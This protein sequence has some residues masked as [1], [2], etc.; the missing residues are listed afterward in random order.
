MLART[1]QDGLDVMWKPKSFTPQELDEIAAKIKDKC[2]YIDA[3]GKEVQSK[4]KKDAAT[5]SA[6]KQENR[7]EGGQ[8]EEALYRKPKEGW[9]AQKNYL[10]KQLERLP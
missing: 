10:L 4:E 7:Q 3:P 1:E 5:P 8:Q 2:D 9:T 6:P